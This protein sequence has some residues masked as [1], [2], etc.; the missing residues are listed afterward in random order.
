MALARVVL[1]VP[2]AHVLVSVLRV[3]VPVAL[4]PV[5]PVAAL[6]VVLVVPVADSR[7]PVD[8]AVALA[9][10][11]AVRPEAPHPVAAVR[12]E[13]P[14]GARTRSVEPRSDAVRVGDA[15]A[16]SSHRR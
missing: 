11:L 1:V 6:P 8:L 16:R 5:V 12:P 4:V 15:V 3:P 2:V 10:A 7:V 14:A 9:V 13:V